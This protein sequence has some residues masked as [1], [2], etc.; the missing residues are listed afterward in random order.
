MGIY[1]N[2]SNNY[3]TSSDYRDVEPFQGEHFNYHELGIIAA[4]ESAANQNAFM[5]AIA[6]SELA[7][8][9]QYGTE[10]MFYESVNIKGI[11]ERIK[12]FFKKI[13]EKIHKIFH[14]FIAKMTSWFSGSKEFVK[15]YEKEIIKNWGLV[16]SDWEFKGY[17]FKNIILTKELSD[18]YQQGV[19]T[20]KASEDPIR[21]ALKASTNATEFGNLLAKYATSTTVSSGGQR[22]INLTVNMFNRVWDAYECDVNNSVI[23]VYSPKNDFTHKPSGKTFKKGKYYKIDGKGKNLTYTEIDTQIYRVQRKIT[24][25]DLPDQVIS[26]LSSILPNAGSAIDNETL[27]KF[28][29]DFND[30]GKDQIRYQIVES[31][32]QNKLIIPLINCDFNDSGA[33]DS[34]EFTEEIH[35][36]I[37]G[38]DDKEDLEKKDI[39]SIYGGSISSMI[40][41]LKDYDKIKSNIEKA[42]RNLIKTLD[43]RIKAVD[44]AQ[45][46]V[47]KD[48]RENTGNA[49]ANDSIV[50]LSSIFQ[51][52]WGFIKECETQVFTAY[53]QGLKDACSQAKQ[54][55]VSV[56]GLNKKMTESYD[57]S[58]S[59]NSEFNN[60]IENTKLV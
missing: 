9:E 30:K 5:K 43:D 17:K 15:K 11:F 50:Q 48:S 13:I 41:F 28:R 60:F 3:Y 21:E 44:T 40:A 36:A 32:K 49:S 34:K 55:A 38:E 6:L 7:S 59:N 29:D 16:K 47:I 42:E 35:K 56:I 1:T 8:V 57:Y 54:I 37:Y 24:V 19:K 39:E 22:E 52:F 25:E 4:T 31:L 2:H 51:S 26:S 33:L 58:S 27:S 23:Q 10:A 53:L 18:T 12:A 46:T 20:D 45:N 14:T